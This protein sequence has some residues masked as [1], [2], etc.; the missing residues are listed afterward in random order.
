MEAVPLVSSVVSPDVGKKQARPSKPATSP[1]P[2]LPRLTERQEEKLLREQEE[3]EQRER[4]E[5]AKKQATP[6]APIKKQAAPVLSSP[7][8]EQ[9]KS[10]SKKRQAS[11]DAPRPSKHQK[12][13][14]RSNLLLPGRITGVCCDLE[15]VMGEMLL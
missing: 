10:H 7:P 5:K 4:W 3:R 8:V 1:V 15:G 14:G 11:P 12:K 13:E 6:S 9:P 2:V